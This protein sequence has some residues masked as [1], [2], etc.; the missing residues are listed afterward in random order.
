MQRLKFS[1]LH[2]ALDSLTQGIEFALQHDNKPNRLK[3]AILLLAQAV[4]LVLKERLSREHW[5]LIF[6]QVD[7]ACQKDAR[8]VSIQGAKKRLVTIAALRFDCEDEKAIKN[9]ARIRNRIQHYEIEIS[10]EQALSYIHA[11]IGFLIKF[12]KDELGQDI[13]DL[14]TEQQHQQ[15]IEIESIHAALKQVA[16][17]RIEELRKEHWSAKPKELIDW[18][19]EVIECPAC[20]QTYYVFSVSANL[21]LCQFCGFEGRFVEAECARCGK[22]FSV[23]AGY[24]SKFPLCE[25]CDIYVQGQ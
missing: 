9:I 2:N 5:S 3:L 7:Q 4:E 21:S 6:A 14:L 20:G 15:L 13:K 23:E 11:A 12:T 22:L 24:E 25:S 17:R 19:F 16:D 1:L 8:T 18:D 10:Y